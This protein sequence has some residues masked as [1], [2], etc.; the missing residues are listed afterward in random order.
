MVALPSE[1]LAKEGCWL[2]VTGCLLLV[3]GCF[4]FM[5]MN[6]LYHRHCESCFG[7]TKQ[8][9]ALTTVTTLHPAHRFH[10]ITIGIPS[11]LTICKGKLF[12][13]H[14]LAQQIHCHLYTWKPDMVDIS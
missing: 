3:A 6:L 8:S 14:V 9:F 12:P 5:L 4:N 10:I 2:L 11:D 1:A 13:L 7:G